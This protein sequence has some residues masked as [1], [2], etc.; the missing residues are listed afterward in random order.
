MTPVC[1][2]GKPFT[3]TPSGRHT[4]RMLHGHTPTRDVPRTPDLD[5]LWRELTKEKP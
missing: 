1:T 2:C 4:H 5:A 3:P